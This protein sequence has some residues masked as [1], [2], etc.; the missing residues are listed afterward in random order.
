MKNNVEKIISKLDKN[1]DN[2]EQLGADA[3][4]YYNR[5]QWDRLKVQIMSIEGYA[6]EIL[7]DLGRLERQ[8]KGE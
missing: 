5:E 1:I 6:E 7:R 3:R 4:F 2:I 8:I